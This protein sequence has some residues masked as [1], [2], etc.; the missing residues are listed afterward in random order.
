MVLSSRLFLSYISSWLETTCSTSSSG[1][2]WLPYN[3]AW[4]VSNACCFCSSDASAVPIAISFSAVSAVCRVSSA[5]S[6]WIGAV[7]R[8]LCSVLIWAT[9]LAVSDCFPFKT[10]SIA[11]HCVCRYVFSALGTALSQN[12]TSPC[13]FSC[14]TFFLRSLIAPLEYVG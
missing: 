3:A 14:Q 13:G 10:I 6:S 4:A 7:A 12:V 11:S 8:S 1:F 5:A 9:V 2:F